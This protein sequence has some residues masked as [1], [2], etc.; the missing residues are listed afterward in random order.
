[1]I[2]VPP[3]GVTPICARK[4]GPQDEKGRPQGI[5]KGA[6]YIRKPGARSEPLETA[7]EWAPLIKRC[8]IH[9]RS[10]LMSLFTDL[11]NARSSVPEPPTETLVQWHNAA[12]TAFLAYANAGGRA[13]GSAGR[14]GES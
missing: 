8:V 13:S 6:Y 5:T 2:T 7:M 10:A 4:S 9:D 1:V 3:H 12:K 11:I 14:T